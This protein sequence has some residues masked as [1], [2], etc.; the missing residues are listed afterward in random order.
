MADS[1]TKKFNSF[2]SRPLQDCTLS[3]VPGVGVSTLHKLVAAGINTPDKLIG[4][5]FMNNRE[6]ELMKAWLVT[7]CAIRSQEAIKISEALDR[8]SKAAMV[9]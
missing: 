1:T 8:K 9:C 4:M 5:Y 7:Q 6:P 2:V 3:D